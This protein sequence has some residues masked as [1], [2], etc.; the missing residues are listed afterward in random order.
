MELVKRKHREDIL[1]LPHTEGRYDEANKILNDIYG[2]DIKVAPG[3]K[4]LFLEKKFSI[5]IGSKLDMN[6]KLTGSINFQNLSDCVINY[7]HN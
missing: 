1:G 5:C 2:K 7:V 6:K 4:S 3:E